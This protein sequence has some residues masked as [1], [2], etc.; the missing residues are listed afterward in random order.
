MSCVNAIQPKQ[1]ARRQQVIRF[2]CLH[3]DWFILFMSEA[4]ET[5]N[6][7]RSQPKWAWFENCIVY[8]ENGVGSVEY[9]VRSPESIVVSR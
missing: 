1:I 8:D 4:L 2:T 6:N 3:I 7:I 5:K 9:G